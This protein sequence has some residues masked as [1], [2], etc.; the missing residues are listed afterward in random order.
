MHTLKKMGKSKQ[1]DSE[2]K[3]KMSSMN[4]ER[5][6]NLMVLNNQSL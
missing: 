6:F 3:A 5:Q 2:K 4:T 1:I